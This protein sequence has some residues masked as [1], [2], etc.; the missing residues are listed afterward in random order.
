MDS[1]ASKAQS[2]KS[3]AAALRG[4]LRSLPRG[5]PF[6]HE[7]DGRQVDEGFRSLDL[8]LLVYAFVLA[9]NHP[10]GN[11]NPSLAD[12]DSTRTIQ[13]AAA[14]FKI[15]FVDHLIIGAAASSTDQPFFSF[16]QADL[17]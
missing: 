14:I 11:P 5:E 15:H 17:F 2:E 8:Q 12:H 1:R 9:H 13:T 4:C 7:A 16:R 3:P 10:S 6:E